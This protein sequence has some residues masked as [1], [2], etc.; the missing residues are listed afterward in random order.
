MAPLVE[1]FPPEE[2]EARA[3][4]TPDNRLRNKRR[5]VDLAKCKLLELVQ[6]E[7]DVV[8]R[9]DPKSVV[10]CQPLVRLFRKCADGLSV[11][12]TSW[13]GLEGRW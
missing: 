12:T 7:C 8:D 13:E 3:Q 9:G 4:Y 2:L 10:R 5:P 11:E 6:Y 1:A